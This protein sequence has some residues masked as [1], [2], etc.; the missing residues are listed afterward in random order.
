MQK[1]IFSV[2]RIFK[3]AMVL[4]L[5]GTVGVQAAP[6]A[7][8]PSSIPVHEWKNLQ[9]QGFFYAGGEYVGAKGKEVM[10][11]QMY[12]EVFV[13][14]RIKQPYPIV[15]YHGAG[16]TGTNWMGTPDGRK[17]W[18]EYFV[19]QGY[20]VY[21][22]DQPG[23]GRSAYH[24]EYDG[25]FRV[26]SATDMEKLF[27]ASEKHLGWKGAEKHTQWPGKGGAKGLIGDPI[28][29]AFYATQVESIAGD[30][31]TQE[32]VQKASSDL[33]DK[34]G[35]AVI[36]THSQSGLFGW[37]IADARP[38]LVKGIIAMEPS[39]PN[40]KRTWGIADVPLT[41][42]PPVTKPGELVLKKIE[43]DGAVGWLQEEPARQLVNLRNIPIIIMT[44]EASYHMPYDHW[45]A[46]YLTQAGIKNTYVRLQD[47]GMS[48]NG[49]MLMMEQNNLEIA[50]F[51]DK[52]I[53]N[54]VK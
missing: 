40:G 19:D 33:L 43:A 49:H 8:V 20:I 5:F 2:M 18:A 14:K 32:M 39:G 45:T 7:S 41:Y 42:D 1:K 31:I 17:G 13:P 35:P 12:V 24:P 34:I 54:N 4:M 46:E 6:M 10:R 16:Q 3:M 52:W 23:R 21:L 29:D 44:G 11:G 28:F 22:V 25:K 30:A 38:H 53:R 47:C 36:V 48:G 27:T 9:G 15:F 26:Y 50:A 37:P 51:V